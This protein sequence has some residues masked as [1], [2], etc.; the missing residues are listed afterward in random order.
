MK[1][2]ARTYTSIDFAAVP[3]TLRA[4]KSMKLVDRQVMTA[5]DLTQQ[6]RLSS[7]RKHLVWVVDLPSRV[8]SMTIGSLDPCQRSRMHRHNYETLLY[9][10]TGWG[11]SVIGECEVEWKA[12]D[13]IYIPVW[14]WHQHINLSESEQAVYVA[15]ENA[16]HLLNLGIALREEG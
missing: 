5:P 9:V 15:C 4:E 12:G 14:T 2:V 11:K 8:L 7:E 6:S 3:P 1:N 16:P 13:A 10:I